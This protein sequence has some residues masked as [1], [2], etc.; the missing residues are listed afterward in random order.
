MTILLRT[1]IYISLSIVECR[2]LHIYGTTNSQEVI[3]NF[4]NS[5]LTNYS[6]TIPQSSKA[7][8]EFLT[9]DSRTGIL[10]ATSKPDCSVINHSPIQC[11]IQ[12]VYKSNDTLITLESLIIYVN[13]GDC[14][15]KF[16]TRKFEGYAVV[17]RGAKIG[18]KIFPL[19]DL[20][21]LSSSLDPR[22]LQLIDQRSRNHFSVDATTGHLL[23]RKSLIGRQE[24]VFNIIVAFPASGRRIYDQKSKPTLLANLQV[25]VDGERRFDQK[26]RRTKRRIKNNPPQF[27]SSYLQANVREDCPIGT[28]VT[29]IIATDPDSGSNGMVRYSMAAS[30]NLLSQSYFSLNADSG[31]ITTRQTLD[32][33]EMGRHYFRVTAKDQGNP[34]LESSTDLTIIVDDINDNSPVFEKSFYAASIPEDKV[35]GDFVLKV[36]ARDEDEGKN[37]KVRYSIQNKKSIDYA[38]DVNDRTGVITVERDL[39]R[40][41]TPTYNLVIKAEDQGTPPKSATVNVK[42]TLTDINDCVPQFTKSSY[43]TTIKENVRPGTL[44]TTIVATDCDQGTNG[45]VFYEIVSGNDMNLFAINKINGQL[46]VKSKLDYERTSVFYLWVSAQDKGQTFLDN[47]TE[48]EIILQDVNDNAP[49]FISDNFKVSVL[50]NVKVG[51][52]FSRVQAIDSD[53]GSNKMIVYSLI[54]T[55]VP[56]AINPLNGDISTT[57]PLDR[58]TNAQYKFG[59]KATDKGTP[60]KEG[61]SQITITVLDVNDNPPKFSKSEYQASI[62]EKATWGASVLQ[63]TAKDPDA[64]VADVTYSVDRF[65]HQRCFRINSL[66]WISLGCKLDYKKTKFYVFTIRASDGLLDSTATVYINVTDANTNSP[67]FKR[68]SYR[69]RI[70]ENAKIGT[71]VLKVV[72]TDDDTGTNAQISYSIEQLVSAFTVDSSSGVIKTTVSL[73]RETKGSYQ[74][75]VTATD[76]G[77][78]PLKKKAYVSIRVLDVNDNAPRFLKSKYTATVK[79]DLRLGEQVIKVSAVDIDRGLNKMIQYSFEVNGKCI[80][81]LIFSK[82]F[83]YKN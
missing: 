83:F 59:V 65:A 26:L 61:T 16:S 76:H 14:F 6:L 72:A 82:F 15:V 55:D 23:L 58:E 28:T 48:V 68:R 41:K 53:D 69:G 74:F 8:L 40:E 4:S 54:R 60:P 78:P 46:R 2:V 20:F 38:F 44:I 56:F 18:T 27:S 13:A 43:R 50:E 33:E 19:T 62:S 22:F 79:E 9:L 77:S 39:D 34:A 81:T 1:L 10:R 3:A 73:D 71:S 31:V 64:G 37:G 66:G 35:M 47:Q 36:R 42:I 12:A 51:Q 30:Q 80:S 24:R 32:R 7:N 57:S 49:E 63:V 52:V 70:L 11:F 5:K 29:T 75:E 45:E 17:S 25:F 67:V 21:R